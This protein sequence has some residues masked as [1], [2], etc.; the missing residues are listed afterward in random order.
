M[1]QNAEKEEDKV[2][3]I[4]VND[5]L[6]KSFKQKCSGEGKFMKDKMVELIKGYVGENNG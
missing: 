6:W 3:I 5:S 4:Q 2:R 1:E